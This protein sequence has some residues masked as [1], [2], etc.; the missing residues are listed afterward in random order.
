[1][2]SFFLWLLIICT[3]FFGFMMGGPSRET[4]SDKLQKELDEFE[5]EITKPDNQ[6]EP[7]RQ[8][9]IDPNISNSLAKKGENIITKIFDL[10]FDAIEKL[11]K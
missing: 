10:S 8:E 5:Q 1:M 6:Y 3:F 4:A 9:K 2:K 11:V 7:V